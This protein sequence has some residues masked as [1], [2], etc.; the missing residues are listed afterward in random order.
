MVEA[1][2][3]EKHLD[4]GLDPRLDPDLDLVPGLNLVLDLEAVLLPEIE[5]EGLLI[6]CLCM[7]TNLTRHFLEC[8]FK[9]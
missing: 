7:K 4:P 3:A 9:S 6:I 2:A 1:A 5:D 8:K